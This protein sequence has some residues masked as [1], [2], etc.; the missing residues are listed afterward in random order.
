[1]MRGLKSL[2]FAVVV[3]GV[4]LAVGCGGTESTPDSNH[5]E[6]GSVESALGRC[7]GSNGTVTCN[8]PPSNACCDWND[9]YGYTCT[10]LGRQCSLDSDCS[11]GAKCNTGIGYCV[12]EGM[13]CKALEL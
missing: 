10:T 7:T 8:V 2:V 3:A 11:S 6:L 4:A 5:L 9:G 12:P 1:M 13:P